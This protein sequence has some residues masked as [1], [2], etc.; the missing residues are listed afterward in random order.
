MKVE[1]TS[2]EPYTDAHNPAHAE[3][4]TEYAEAMGAYHQRIATA[5]AAFIMEDAQARAGR[6]IEE[7]DHRS[8]QILHEQDPEKYD[9]PDALPEFA[10]PDAPNLSLEDPPEPPSVSPTQTGTR[11][12]FKVVD[13]DRA[14]IAYV[15]GDEDPN[16]AIA[17]AVAELPPVVGVSEGDVI[18][19]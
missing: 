9:A 5:R 2:T 6:I 1:I 7:A 3:A 16:E 8:M 4:M 18:D 10:G 19:V 17:R 11:I 12:H 15:F 14:G 13:D